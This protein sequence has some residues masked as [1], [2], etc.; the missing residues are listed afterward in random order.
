MGTPD[1]QSQIDALEDKV[2]A[3]M[4]LVN[5]LICALNDAG[6][7]LRDKLRIHSATAA[8]DLEDFRLTDA[9]AFLDE[10]RD[11]ADLLLRPAAKTWGNKNDGERD[12]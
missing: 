10:L 3:L 12:P 4:G 8:N 11:V 2:F 5:A 6:I 9:A 1:L 7:P